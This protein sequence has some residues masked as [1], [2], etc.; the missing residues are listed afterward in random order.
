VDAE[1]RLEPS[2]PVVGLPET[3]RFPR[4]ER[5]LVLDDLAAETEGE[6]TIAARRPDGSLLA[7]SNPLLVRASRAYDSF[8]ADMHGQSEETIGTNTVRQYFS[9]GRNLAFLDVMCHQGND[10]QIT[11]EFWR[12]L[13]EITTEFT[14]PGRFVAFPGYEW[15]ANTGLGG[16]HNVIF[17]RENETIHRSSH[18]LVY[19]HFDADT[20]CHTIEAL[21]Q[22][23]RDVEH[24][25]YVHVGGRYAFLG[26][27]A[28]EP[29][30]V[31]NPPRVAV[32][33]HSAWGTSEWLLHDAFRAGLRVGVVANSDGHKGRPGASHPGASRF[34]SYGGYTC[35]LAE[36]LTREA[37]F[38]CLTER[39]HYATSGAR[40]HLYLSVS[41]GRQ[42]DL[43]MGTITDA[44][45]SEAQLAVTAVGT[46]P[47]LRIEVMNGT[48]RVHVV[49]PYRAAD[50]GSRIR[51]EWEGAEYRGR[52]RETSW[53]GSVSFSGAT[54]RGAW[55][56]NFWN[57][58]KPL[59]QESDARVSFRSLTTGGT[60]GVDF[61]LHER[62]GGSITVDTPLVKEQVTLETVRAE[63]T[64]FEA[65]GL[66]RRLRIYRLP[67]APTST[68]VTARA[69]VP[70]RN[71]SDNPVYVRVV[72]EDGHM[73]WS[74]PV[75][76]PR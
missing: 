7:R 71:G 6:L 35:F 63:P 13:Q 20:D 21:H 59:V 46:A 3:V 40:M 17:L 70:L 65:G 28:S 52:G 69:T 36:E 62:P 61:L 14:D 41:C 18:A 53:D 25:L 34:G 27:Y 49:W 38:R 2:L 48:D 74:S 76:L 19:D 1:L 43:P 22:A 39:R 54:I 26:R 44:E 16:D 75:Y 73:G 57:P 55:G 8:W 51:V 33:V 66:G 56:V 42:T 10:F 24:F 32:E 29:R 37:I 47:I 50:V 45:A 15:S 23:L 72:Q 58:D 5:A 67:E 12:H 4:G 64:V 11:R 9:F 60:S 30:P 31:A 68:T